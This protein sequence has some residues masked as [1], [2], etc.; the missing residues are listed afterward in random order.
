MKE[1]NLYKGIVVFMVVDLNCQ[2]LSFFKPFQ[3][4]HLTDSAGRDIC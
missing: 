1:G 4:S 3:K 2:Y